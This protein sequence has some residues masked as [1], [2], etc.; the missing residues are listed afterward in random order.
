[1]DALIS[2]YDNVLIYYPNVF[3]VALFFISILGIILVSIAIIA[4]WK[5]IR[6][7]IGEIKSNLEQIKRIKIKERKGISLV[8]MARVF[9]EKNKISFAHIIRLLTISFVQMVRVFFI[10][11]NKALGYIESQI[12]IVIKKIGKEILIEE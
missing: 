12:E 7:I 11:I 2:F 8:P 5:K 4:L 6:K 10:R 3:F 1:M 9:F